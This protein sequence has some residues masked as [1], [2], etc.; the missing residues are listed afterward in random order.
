MGT[1]GIPLWLLWLGL[2]FWVA[3]TV[4]LLVLW[5]TERARHAA[6]QASHTTEQ[7]L[8][9]QHNQQQQTDADSLQQQV[10]SLHTQLGE[11]HTHL[12]ETTAQLA[13]TQAKL[14]SQH[15]YTSTQLAQLTTERDSLTQQLTQHTNRLTELEKTLAATQ[16]ELDQKT[17]QLTQ[18]EQQY[19]QELPDQFQLIGK[20]VLQ[21]LRD[22]LTA[23][24]A[25][26]TE[27]R[28]QLLTKDVK[29]LLEPMEKLI[30]DQQKQVLALSEQTIRETTSLKEQLQQTFEQTQQLIAAKNRIVSVLTD[31]KGRGDWGELQLE[32]L[33]DASG[34]V[35]G[36]HYVLQAHQTDGGRPD[37]EIRL[38]NN[39]VIFIDVK[40]LIG[41][42]ERL[43]QTED[44]DSTLTRQVD[45]LRAEIKKLSKRSY[46][47]QNTDSVDFVVLFVPRE[48]LLRIPLAHDPTLLT[49]AMNDNV[50]LASPLILLGLLKV[51]H[52]GWQQFDISQNARKV[53]EAGKDLHKQAKLFLER[54]A[55]LDDK[56]EAV[57]DSYKDV[58]TA[59][60][61]RIGVLQKIRKLEDLG[62]ATGTDTL[63]QS[64]RLGDKFPELTEAEDDTPPDILN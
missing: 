21:T 54:F 64:K 6:S 52:Q 26:V 50:V 15:Q 10:A 58:R 19:K 49:D 41:S 61:G 9:T 11:Q 59:I 38:P 36:I 46:T 30:A 45:S 2:A 5:L 25:Q 24:T 44:T 34:L 47:S 4:A 16:A 32:K 3:L 40:T 63:E 20:T 42:L 8:L 13:T 43:E 57:R 56:I 31:S 17:L 33:L 37:V 27:Q 12:T 35:K 62:C 55:L 53:H 28:Q 48:S 39:R 51:V 60:T 23:D 7:R 1:N 18:R 29:G 14:D 22:Q